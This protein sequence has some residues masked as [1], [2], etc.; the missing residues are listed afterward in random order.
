MANG[1]KNATICAALTWCLDL[2]ASD[3]TAYSQR[4]FK[5]EEALMERLGWPRAAA[6]QRVPT[7]GAAKRAYPERH[8]AAVRWKVYRM[9]GRASSVVF[10]FIECFYNPTRRHSTLGYLSPVQFEKPQEA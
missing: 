7:V 5:A 3:R 10:D 8:E 4:T 9:R 2:C 6:L 1:I